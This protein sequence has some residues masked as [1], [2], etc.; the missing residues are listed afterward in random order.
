MCSLFSQYRLL[1]P[2]EKIN[3]QQGEVFGIIPGGA[4]EVAEFLN[5]KKVLFKLYMPENLNLFLKKMRAQNNDAQ[6]ILYFDGEVN[7]IKVG[8]LDGRNFTEILKK[9]RKLAK[10]VKGE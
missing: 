9:A 1:E 5:S 8:D 3:G 10:K 7:M 2:D 4:N 6:T